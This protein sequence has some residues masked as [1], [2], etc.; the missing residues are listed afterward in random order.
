[1]VAGWPDW[2][3]LLVL[4]SLWTEFSLIF[5]P[6][7]PQ[8]IAPGRERGSA[9]DPVK[10]NCSG[11]TVLGQQKAEVILVSVLGIQAWSLRSETSSEKDSLGGWLRRVSE[12]WP[13]KAAEVWGSGSSGRQLVNWEQVSSETPEHRPPRAASV[14]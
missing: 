10:A 4:N 11:R 9:N 6:P 2:F 12:V 8:G 7:A 13:T 5:R 14:P 1:M 3:V